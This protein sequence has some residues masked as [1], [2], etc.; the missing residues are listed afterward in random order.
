MANEKNTVFVELY[1]LTI[2]ERPD[3]RFG[4]VVVPRSINEDDL[5]KMA[6][7]RRTDLNPNTL[8]TSINILQELAEEC[9]LRGDS[10]RFGLAHF[11]LDC[12]G[13]FI[14]DNA[15]WDSKQHRLVARATPTSSLREAINK[16]SVNIRG[17][18]TIGTVINS[19]TDVTTGE[20]NTVLTPNGGVNLTGSKIKI[21]GDHP[22]NGIK[23]VNQ[24]TSA[25]LPIPE[26]A[27]LV[28]DPSKISFIL[29]RQMAAGDYKITLT[30]QF[31]SGSVI[32]KE[33]RSYTFEY[34]LSVTP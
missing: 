9:I 8:K 13:M 15:K 30:T 5:I 14:G 4:K 24:T 23:L 11:S 10:V 17:M 18:A 16:A 31:T 26:N 34:V 19:V 22:S 1:D 27:I 20:Q 25:E 21:A 3:D 28:N 2:T 32:L 29:P 33:P 12:R 7:A 6:V